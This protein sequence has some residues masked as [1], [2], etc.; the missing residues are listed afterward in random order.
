MLS[1]YEVVIGAALDGERQFRTP[2]RAGQARR[3]STERA[4]SQ[5]WIRAPTWT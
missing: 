5:P 3:T 2:A 1:D 4:F